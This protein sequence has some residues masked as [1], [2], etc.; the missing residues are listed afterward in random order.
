MDVRVGHKEGWV[1]KNW[2]FWTVVL[3]KILESLLDCEEIKPVNPKGNQSWIFIWNTDAG[4]EVPILWPPDMKNWL[5][6]KDPDAGK[7]WRQEKET[8]E[9]K[10]VGGITHSMDVNFSKLREMVKD[11]EAFTWG[12]LGSP[13][14]QTQLSDWTRKEEKA[15]SSCF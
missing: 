2:C 11:R 14:G 7:D 13:K 4:A 10:M 8:I 15:N 6:G 9:S 3:E 5:T 12:P 1:L